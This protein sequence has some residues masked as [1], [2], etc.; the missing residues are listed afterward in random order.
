[1]LDFD[2]AA[3]LAQFPGQ[4]FRESA[5][6]VPASC[7]PDGDATG[8]GGKVGVIREVGEQLVGARCVKDDVLNPGVKAIEV[9]D[10]A[11]RSRVTEPVADVLD[12]VG[13]GRDG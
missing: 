9:E 2:F 1:M 5:R 3:A 11:G 13:G 8:A 6:A 4:K 12:P 7:T 10:V